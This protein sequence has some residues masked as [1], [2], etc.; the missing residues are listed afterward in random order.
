MLMFTEAQ[1]WH[2][3]PRITAVAIFIV[4]ALANAATATGVIRCRLLRSNSTRAPAAG[5]AMT[6][7]MCRP[8]S[9]QRPPPMPLCTYR[10]ART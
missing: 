6:R 5:R 4:L 3:L 10:V 7:P 2:T 8:R 1:L 9:T